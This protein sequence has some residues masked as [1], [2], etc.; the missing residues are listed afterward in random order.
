MMPMKNLERREDL[1]DPTLLGP[2]HVNAFNCLRRKAR[3]DYERTLLPVAP[4]TGALSAAALPSSL[5]VE[6][7]STSGGPGSPDPGYRGD[8]DL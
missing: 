8:I 1:K 5:V 6:P 3:A 7:G 4:V 2:G